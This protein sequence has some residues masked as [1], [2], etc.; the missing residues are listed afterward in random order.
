MKGNT[1]NGNIITDEEYKN[2]PISL[3]CINNQDINSIRIA[4]ADPTNKNARRCMYIRNDL[5]TDFF[6]EINKEENVTSKTDD[7]Y[8]GSV[9]KNNDL[10]NS[11]P[12]IDTSK[13][14]HTFL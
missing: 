11:N 9:E 6:L 10:F 14:K 5:G 12:K 2:G 8:F 3:I 7:M 13:P 1:N 4:L